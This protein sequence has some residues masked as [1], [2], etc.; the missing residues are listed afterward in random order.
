PALRVIAYQDG[1]LPEPRPAFVQRICAVRERPAPK[2]PQ[3]AA[4]AAETQA[5]TQGVPLARYDLT[6]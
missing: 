5:V 4:T 2:R 1:F 3:N 6:G